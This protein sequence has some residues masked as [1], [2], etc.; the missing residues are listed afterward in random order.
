MPDSKYAEQKLA[1]AVMALTLGPGDIKARL[2]DAYKHFQPV[3]RDD[4]PENLRG[5][6]D[7]LITSLTRK[8]SMVPPG[9]TTAV[10]GAV[11]QMLHFMRREPCVKIAARIVALRDQLHQHNSA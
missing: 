2:V 1:L 10:S 7:A 4:L 9:T 3:G 6:F 5:E 8:A 11:E